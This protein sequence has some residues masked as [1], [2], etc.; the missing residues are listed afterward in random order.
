MRACEIQA[1]TRSTS[2]Q[3]AFLSASEQNK[4]LDLSLLSAVMAL[5]TADTFEARDSLYQALQ[6]RPGLLSFLHMNEG[7]VSSVAFSPDGKTIAAGIH[8]RRQRGGA[9]GRGRTRTLLGEPLAVNEGAVWSVAFS[10][11]GK[12]IAAGYSDGRQR[13]RRGAVGRGRTQTA[14]RRSHST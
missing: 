11:D 8:R 12:T 1:R 2:R 5:R 9:L 14:G 6:N 10:P 4:R 13:R 7:A 3:L